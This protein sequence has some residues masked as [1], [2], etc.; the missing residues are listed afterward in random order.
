MT[1]MEVPVLII[2]GGGCGLTSSIFLSDLGVNHVLVERHEGTSQLPKAHYL[3]QRTMEIFRQ[4]DLADTVYAVGVPIEKMGKVRWRTSLGGDGPLDQRT[5]YEMDS[6]GGYSLRERYRADSPCD[7]CNYPQLRLEPLLRRHAEQRGPGRLRFHHEVIDW[8]QTANGV[9]VNV[10]DRGTEQQL[11]IK[12]RYVIAADG[13]KTVGPR[14]EIPMNGPMNMADFVTTHFSADLSEYWDDQ[15]LITWFLNP[16][17]GTS[18]GAGAMVQMGPTWGRHSEEWVLHFGFRPDD[19]ERFNEDTL[20]PKIRQLLRLPNLQPKVHKVSHWMLD[21]VVAERWRAGD[22]FLAGDAAHRQPP[23]T[24]LGLNTG[25]ADAHNLA[26]KLAAVLH[27]RADAALLD[28]YE[29]ERKPAATYGADWAMLAFMNRSVIDAGIGLIPGAPTAFNVGAFHALFAD[30]VMGRALRSR[31]AEAFNT[32]R[33]EFHAHDVEL[34]YSYESNAVVPDG[35]PAVPRSEDGT[36]Y[37]ATGRPGHRLPHAWLERDDKQVSTHDL[38]ARD[39]T[40]VLIAGARGDAWCN[41]ARQAAAKLGV[42]IKVVTVGPGGD[43]ADPTG[44]WT[45]V[46]GV[47]D[48]GALIV[49][50]DQHVGWRSG[51]HQAGAERA[52]YDSLQRMLG[53]A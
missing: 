49:R 12:A 38:V 21:R 51:G 22:I 44:V 31:A 18:W 29:S 11:T 52:L 35:T 28:S 32:Q 34:G 19:P 47:G 33:R 23:T 8:E 27:G 14:L 4:H 37:T 30:S 26:W 50:P 43:Y 2:G 36:V 45:R 53:H 20:I 6:F 17:G 1:T 3:N 10:V 39:G 40:L 41:A 5:I 42:A 13:G 48:D 24:G 7:A 9:V 16:E 15:C 46:S 25:I